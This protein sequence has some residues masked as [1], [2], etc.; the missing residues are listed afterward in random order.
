MIKTRIAAA[1]L[2]VTLHAAA[3]M[4]TAANA[5]M[6]EPPPSGVIAAQDEAMERCGAQVRSFDP[7]TGTYTSFS[8]ETVVCPYLRSGMDDDMDQ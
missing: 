1:Q 7:E 4:S 2:A 8:G 6:M 3:T 5:Q